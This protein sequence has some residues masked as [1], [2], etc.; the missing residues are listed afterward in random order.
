MKLEGVEGY[1]KLRSW[2]ANG[3]DLQTSRIK[4][5]AT[6]DEDFRRVDFLEILDLS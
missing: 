5:I 1:Q 3:Y 2:D 4:R 6:F